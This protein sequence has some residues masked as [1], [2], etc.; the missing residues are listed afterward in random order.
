MN[1]YY[2]GNL[3]EVNYCLMAEFWRRYARTCSSTWGEIY[4]TRRLG[5]PAARHSGSLSGRQARG[6]GRGGAAQGCGATALLPELVRVARL[7]ERSPPRPLPP[8]GGNKGGSAR[9]DKP[10]GKGAE[11][12]AV[13][14][15]GIA[16]F[17]QERGR[18]GV[19]ATQ[20][21]EVGGP[22]ARASC[23]LAVGLSL[24]RAAQGTAPA[25]P[26]SEHRGGAQRG[27]APSCSGAGSCGGRGG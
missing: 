14:R 8:A 15:P 26:V 12:L 24:A 19:G 4:R 13:S 27:G 25:R 5:P 10:R 17:V 2:I 1:T 9:G 21:R 6:A 18:G 23:G 7:D 16:R 22:R 11:R 3:S 20:T